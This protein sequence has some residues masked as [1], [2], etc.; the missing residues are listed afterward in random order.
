MNPNSPEAGAQRAAHYRTL[1][2]RRDRLTVEAANPNTSLSIIAEAGRVESE[3]RGTLSRMIAMGDAIPVLTP[4]PT[5]LV[6]VTHAPEAG[7]PEAA[8]VAL[9][10]Q[11]LASTSRAGGAVETADAIAARILASDGPGEQPHADREVEAAAARIISSDAGAEDDEESAEAIAA[12]IA[13][14]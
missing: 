4:T 12:R 8:T 5:A 6:S 14:A 2:D 7:E 10:A 11:I 13:A 3:V 9:T 1:I